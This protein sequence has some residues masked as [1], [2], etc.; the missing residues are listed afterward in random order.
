VDLWVPPG[1]ELG[2]YSSYDDY[3]GR[4]TVQHSM[5]ELTAL[6]VGQSE[7]K[8]I[9]VSGGAHGVYEFKW[10]LTRL[11]DAEPVVGPVT[12]LNEPNTRD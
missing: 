10:R 5:E 3:I 12:R 4:Q 6:Q 11:P 2:R 1:M 9:L 8:N 7:L